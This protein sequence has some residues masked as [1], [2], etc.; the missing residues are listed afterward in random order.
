[1]RGEMWEINAGLS[2]DIYK[3]AESVAIWLGPESNNSTLAIG[4]LNEVVAKAS[5]SGVVRSFIS[6]RDRWQELEAV[7]SLFERDYW[8]RL[9]VVQEIFNARFVEVYCGS[10]KLPYSI[11]ENASR[12]FRDLKSDLESSSPEGPSTGA[13]RMVS[14]KQL[15][16]SQVSAY[17]GPGN[18][19][20]CYLLDK[21]QKLKHAPDN[22][23]F[24]ALLDAMRIFRRKLS[25]EPKD[26][27][28][29]ILGILP[30]RIRNRIPADYRL[31][32]KDVYTN[33][34][35][36][37]IYTTNRLDVICETVHFP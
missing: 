13:Q 30:E 36:T 35:D 2:S 6:S 10:I 20:D 8:D 3:G 12:T 33:V 11:Y 34:V 37:L 7:I 16:I 15:T 24:G 26:K 19:F 25:E 27:V 18:L 5:H 28:F 32:V 1:M 23:L 14:H 29:G 17:E 22:I 31:S 4:L 21:F 9:W